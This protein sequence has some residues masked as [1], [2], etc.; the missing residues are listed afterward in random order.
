MKGNSQKYPG[1]KWNAIYS[2]MKDEIKLHVSY[3]IKILIFTS[4]QMKCVSFRPVSW[5]YRIHIFR[6]S[7]SRDFYVYEKLRTIENKR[8]QYAVNLSICSQYAIMLL[9]F[10]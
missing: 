9:M 1:I 3:D 2:S 10:S 4:Q 8:N 7:L 5:L 6:M